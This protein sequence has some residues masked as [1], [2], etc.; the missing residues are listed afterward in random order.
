MDTKGTMYT[1]RRDYIRS[2]N[3]ALAVIPDFE[4]IAYVN[5][6]MGKEYVKIWDNIGGA[7]YLDISDMHL[8]DVFHSI[9]MSVK[10]QEP[11]NIVN[12][13]NVMRSLVPLFKKEE[14]YGRN[15]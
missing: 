4:G 6:A 8:S 12:D 10:G 9:A 5:T 13:I 15:A 14:E 2:L 11:R 7:A 1:K 3:I